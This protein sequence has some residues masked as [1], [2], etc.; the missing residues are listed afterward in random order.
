MLHEQGI[1]TIYARIE[2]DGTI[3]NL[4]TLGTPSPS[5]EQATKEAVSQWK[6]K[7][8]VC[9]GAPVVDELVIYTTFA[10]SGD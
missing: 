10:V 4:R 1:V 2:P 8:R 9:G 5:L 7:P 3:P 6:Y